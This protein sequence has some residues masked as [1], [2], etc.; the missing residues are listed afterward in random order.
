MASETVSEAQCN[1]KPSDGVLSPTPDML[2][3]IDKNASCLV[4]AG[5]VMTGDH[6]KRL[7]QPCEARL[8]V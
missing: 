8:Y 5:E 1:E 7:A 3:F 4:V 2:N 6:T